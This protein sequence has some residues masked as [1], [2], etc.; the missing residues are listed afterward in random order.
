M[1]SDA[2]DDGAG[3]WLTVLVAG[4]IVVVA[5]IGYL[6]YNG[7]ASDRTNMVAVNLPSAAPAS[8]PAPTPSP[9]PKP[10]G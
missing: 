8:S 4:L 1:D 2:G 5:V 7:A 10:N 9:L 3:A 6:V